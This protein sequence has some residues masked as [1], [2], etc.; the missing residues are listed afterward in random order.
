[1]EFADLLK[2]V[3]DLP[4]FRGSLLLAGDLDPADVRRQLSRWKA[5]G[6]VIQLRRNLYVLAPPWRRVEPHPFL[7][8]NELHGPSY[9]SLQSL[10]AYHE[11][12]PEAVPVTTSVTTGRPMGF[13]TALGQYTYRHLGPGAFFGYR[14][15]R[16]LG[17]QEALVAEPA[18]ALLDLAYLTPEGERAGHLESLRLEE[19]D[20][21]GEDQLVA[22]V[23]RWAK[24]KVQRA[25]EN[26]L[27]LKH[28]A[29][30]GH[31]AA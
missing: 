22:Y 8:A 31:N 13:R 9:V 18:K 24:P 14:R 1:M 30:E 2:I 20:Q 28:A 16:V 17:D 3:G 15:L 29:A 12:I 7:V 11:M 10:L 25:G 19:F 6:K 4:L 21:I 23:R 5:S 26:I 27:R